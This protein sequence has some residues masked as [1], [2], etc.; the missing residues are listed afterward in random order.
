M[1]MR[2]AELGIEQTYKPKVITDA[3]GNSVVTLRLTTSNDVASLV[4]TD[5]NGNVIPQHQIEYVATQLDENVVEWTVTITTS[6]VGTYTYVVTGAYENGYTDSSKSVKVVVT[7]ENPPADVQPDND[8]SETDD[9]SDGTFFD[10]I[11]GIYNKII[12]FFR[13]IFALLGFSI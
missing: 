11:T 6:E 1:G 8:D 12:E 9:D 13:T 4:V 3:D 2:T 10:F 7:I 5:E